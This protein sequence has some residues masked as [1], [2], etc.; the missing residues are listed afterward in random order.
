MLYNI[1]DPR[2]YASSSARCCSAIGWQVPTLSL[3]CTVS[4]LTLCLQGLFMVSILSLGVMRQSQLQLVLSE[5]RP[6][7][8]S[9]SSHQLQRFPFILNNLSFNLLI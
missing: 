6:A 9:L 2:A 8:T 7:L 3:T 4:F 5:P 1:L